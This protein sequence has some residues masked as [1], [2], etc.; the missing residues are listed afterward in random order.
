MPANAILILQRKIALALDCVSWGLR[1]QDLEAAALADEFGISFF[2]ADYKN[3]DVGDFK[4]LAAMHL[5]KRCRGAAIKG[6]N[7]N[8]SLADY[9]E[10]HP[11]FWR[12][13]YDDS[14]PWLVGSVVTALATILMLMNNVNQ[15]IAPA[16]LFSIAGIAVTGALGLK[17][18]QAR[19]L[20][21]IMREQLQRAK[22]ILSHDDEFK[23][24]FYILTRIFRHTYA[25]D[26]NL[27]KQLLAIKTTLREA[28]DISR[29]VAKKLICDRAVLPNELDVFLQGVIKCNFGPGTPF[30]PY[31]TRLRYGIRQVANLFSAT[32]VA[33]DMTSAANKGPVF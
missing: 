33:Q 22:D 18:K 26:V 21:K 9:I 12:R 14:A 20:N 29:Y 7:S 27:R 3:L 32:A 5:I 23:S 6:D 30:K 31:A 10:R 24:A 2:D 17:A 11:L 13:H 1:L 25:Q 16:L 8:R 28:D 19:L 15:K 4:A